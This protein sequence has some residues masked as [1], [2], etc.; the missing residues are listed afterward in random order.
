MQEARSR[1]IKIHIKALRRDQ[2]NNPTI[3][4]EG[5]FGLFPE[6]PSMDYHLSFLNAFYDKSLMFHRYLSKHHLE[7]IQSYLVHFK[8]ETDAKKREFWIQK[9]EAYL[10]KDNLML[11][12]FHHVND[13]E[14]DPMIQDI[15]LDSFG[16]VDLRKLWIE[17]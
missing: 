7:Y 4:S 12:L 17:H 2:Y 3:E 8:N 16:Y 9:I 5:D 14:F 15:Q 11:F 10:K 13:H 1:G 6:V